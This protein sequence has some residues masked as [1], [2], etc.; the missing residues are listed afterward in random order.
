M[1]NLNKA[2]FITGAGSGIGFQCAKTLSALGYT[3]YGT[4]VNEQ[5]HKN[6]IENIPKNF[7]PFIMNILN[8]DD[9]QNVKQA[10]SELLDQ[11]PLYALINIAGVIYNGPLMELSKKQFEHILGVNVVGVHAMTQ[12]L[13]PFLSHNSEPSKIINMSS[14]SGLRTLPFTGFYSASK[15][16]L[17]SLSTAMKL[18]FQ[19][20]GIKVSVV[21]P[22]QIQTPMAE[23]ILQDVK[24]YLSHPIYGKAMQRF[25]D[26]SKKSFETGLPAIAVVDTIVDILDAEKP[27]Y[28]YEIHTNKLRDYYLLRKLPMGLKDYLI[29]KKTGL[30]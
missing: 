7:H 23:K 4:V 15:F 30:I 14:Q 17:E 27:E 19:P 21:E 25:Y 29:S 2:V 24:K 3:V 28:Q 8:Q 22:A 20:L 1:K 6:S 26:S 5:E 13:L 9:I 18:E 11:K 12:A 16:A 10:L